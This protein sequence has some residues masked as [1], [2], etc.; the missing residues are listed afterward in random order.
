MM[1]FEQNYF[2]NLY[3]LYCIEL[4]LQVPEHMRGQ[5]TGQH[6][7]HDPNDCTNEPPSER[8]LIRLHRQV[9]VIANGGLLQETLDI[10]H[11]LFPL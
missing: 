3:R 9:V 8:G 1:S 4:F 6:T 5:V 2:Q 7:S 11:K 10:A